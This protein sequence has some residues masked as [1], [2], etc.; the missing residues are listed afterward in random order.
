MEEQT[1]VVLLYYHYVYIDDT[2][3]VQRWQLD[4]C[5]KYGI[6]G[7]IRISSEGLNG[8]LS[9]EQDSI[10]SYIEEFQ[11]KSELRPQEI[12]WKIS[13]LNPHQSYDSQKFADLRVQITRE[14]VSL[15]LNENEQK[16]LI[17]SK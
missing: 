6:N 17:Q 16:L 5:E 12:H 3:S 10:R 14:V 15:D 13:G 11:M 1:F 9:G 4:I 2:V 8:T 7:R